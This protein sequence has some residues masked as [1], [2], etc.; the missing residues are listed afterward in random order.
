MLT[1]PGLV[2]PLLALGV[3]LSLWKRGGLLEV[4]PVFLSAQLVGVFA[5]ALVG[6]TIGLVFMGLG[7]AIAALAALLPRPTGGLSLG[8]AALTG[9]T[10]MLVVFEGHGVFELPVFTHLGLL[11]GGNLATALAAGLANLG[12]TRVSGGLM[13]IGWRVA[14]SWIGAILILTLA[15]EL[16]AAPS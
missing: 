4:W 11:F 14:A 16:T 6:P 10:A 12:L 13:R 9:L 15:F 1:D 3:F 7:I 2:L 8:L 5:A